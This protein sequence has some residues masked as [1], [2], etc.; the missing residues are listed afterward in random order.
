M[1]ALVAFLLANSVY[2]YELLAEVNKLPTECK[3]GDNVEFWVNTASTVK[4]VT[5]DMSS[6]TFRP[7]KLT[8]EGGSTFTGVADF[9]SEMTVTRIVEKAGGAGSQFTNK[10]TFKKGMTV[11]C[12][13]TDPCVFTGPITNNALE[14]RLLAI[15]ARLDKLE[16]NNT[17]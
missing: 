13:Q 12:S 4:S 6:S 9:Q 17:I 14:Q 3:L 15:E 10:A 16:P 1:F 7:K 8:V 11:T 5:L 2:G